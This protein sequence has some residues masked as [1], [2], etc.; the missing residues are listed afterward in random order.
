M[1]VV[2]P[3]RAQDRF[4]FIGA[5]IGIALVVFAGFA[6]TYYLKT[7][8]DT[9]ALPWFV[10]LHGLV[11]SSWIVLFFVQ[12]FLIEKHRVDLHRRLGI[13]GVVLAVVI[14][15]LGM[16][17]II[18]AAAREVHAHSKHMHGFLALLALDPYTLLV[19]ATMVA[20][21]IAVRHRRSDVHKRLML[22][23][24]L[25]LAVVAI[26]R[27]PFPSVTWFWVVWGLLL[28]VPLAVDTVRHRRLHPV[29]GWGAPFLFVSSHA[30]FTFAHT[31]A[32]QHFAERLVS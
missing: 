10:H 19:F 18:H 4:L 31:P 7:W 15:V 5:A 21:A 26:S 11:M 16:F 28:F 25:S 1:N 12:T 22:L 8:F 13:L 32:W 29:F 27:L 24:T 17:L 14:V 30:V 23:A 2:V 6:R 9:P 3:A 20:Y